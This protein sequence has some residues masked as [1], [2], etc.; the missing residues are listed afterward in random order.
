MQLHWLFQMN[1]KTIGKCKV[2]FVPKHHTMKAYRGMGLKIHAF[3]SL[4]L[5]GE[6]WSASCSNC[7]GSKDVVP[8]IHWTEAW[9]GSWTDLHLMVRIESHPC[10]E[11]NTNH[12]FCLLYVSHVYVL[13]LQ[14]DILEGRK[15]AKPP[16]RL[17]ESIQK[18]L[19]KRSIGNRWGIQ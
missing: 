13:L 8:I 16:H 12:W 7:F 1:H 2:V 14:Q 6:S 3:L 11:W 15:S 9:L 10:Q 19:D 18:E 4:A 17:P 5:D